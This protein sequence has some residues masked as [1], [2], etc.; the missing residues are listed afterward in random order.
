MK[1]YTNDD[2]IILTDKILNCLYSWH[3]NYLVFQKADDYLDKKINFP[4][5]IEFL[6]MYYLDHFFHELSELYTAFHKKEDQEILS[7]FN[8]SEDERKKLKGARHL[9]AHVTND[10]NAVN[11]AGQE[12]YRSTTSGIFVKDMII[13][14]KH[15]RLKLKSIGK[16]HD[17]TERLRA[18]LTLY[19]ADFVPENVKKD[20]LGE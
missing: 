9:I 8:A 15:I 6:G 17:L 10:I 4:K 20:L 16:D 3:Q 11:E 13:M 12:M 2:L 18:Q 14:A 1:P 7:Q 5:I 19:P